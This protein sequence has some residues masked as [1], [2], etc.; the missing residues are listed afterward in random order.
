[1]IK[2]T[3][4]L[5]EEQT[6]SLNCGDLV[7]LTGTIYTARDAVHKYLNDGG[8]L[9]IDLTGAAIYHCGPVTT[10]KD[11]KWQIE[12][13]GPTTSIREEPY[14]AMVLEKFGVRAII[15]KGGM[16][17]KTLKAC[18][19]FGCVYLSAY[20]GCA[21]LLA[22]KIVRVPNVFFYDQFGAPE[23]IWQLEVKDFPAVVTMDSN[24]ISLHQD[25]EELSKTNLINL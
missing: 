12:A 18:R 8:E 7:S 14:T 6:R 2:L 9:P 15:G 19:Q 17:S 5:N 10:K 16:G 13:A 20:G 4:P 3:L 25:I 11:G 21:Q 23:A 24:G 22:D 1:M